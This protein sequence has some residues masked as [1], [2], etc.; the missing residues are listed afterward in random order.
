MLESRPLQV[1]SRRRQDSEPRVGSELAFSDTETASSV[2]I[3][4]A[5]VPASAHEGETNAPGRV[6]RMN[7]E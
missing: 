7:V 4:T 5:W 2:S 3:E 1:A 6:S